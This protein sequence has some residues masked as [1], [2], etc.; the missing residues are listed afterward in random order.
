VLVEGGSEI[1]AAFLKAGLVDR[2][3]VYRAG[4]VLG[5]DGRSAIG[6]LGLDQLGFAPRLS[7]VSVRSLGGDV[8]ESW[9]SPA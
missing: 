2:L 5:A 6:A 4:A 1:A 3:S 8:V 9:R 7:L